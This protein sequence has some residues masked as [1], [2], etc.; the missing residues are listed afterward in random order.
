[1]KTVDRVRSE[2]PSE[3]SF[4]TFFSLI[5]LGLFFMS[6]WTESSLAFHYIFLIFAISFA[7]IAYSIPCLLIPFNLGWLK[8]GLFLAGLVSP[9]TIF[10]IYIAT[11][12]PVGGLLRITFF[13]KQIFVNLR[14]KEVATEKPGW[15]TRQTKINWTE[16]Y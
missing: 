8:F 15:V 3:R 11:V 13:F 14:C 6:F 16:E 10:L 1:M 5:F 9:I 4:G 12:V 7:W 2:R